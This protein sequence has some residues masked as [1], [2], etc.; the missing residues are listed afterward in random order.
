MGVEK[1]HTYANFATD[2]T[3]FLLCYQKLV[4][5]GANADFRVHRG[6]KRPIPTV[7]SKNGKQNVWLPFTVFRFQNGK[8]LTVGTWIQNVTKRSR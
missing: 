8:R 7:Q 3:S 1:I 4:G 2:Q 5:L 6:V